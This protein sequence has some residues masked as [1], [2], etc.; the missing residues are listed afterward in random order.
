IV[1]CV[2][3][4]ISSGLLYSVLNLKSIKSDFQCV[5]LCS[6]L[7]YIIPFIVTVLGLFV[8]LIFNVPTTI[9]FGI[10]GLLFTLIPYGRLVKDLLKNEILW[11]IFVVASNGILSVFAVNMILF[12]VN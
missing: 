6:N 9:T 3:G 4:L 12:S 1:G 5:L 11:Y 8:R 2:M 7:S 10:S